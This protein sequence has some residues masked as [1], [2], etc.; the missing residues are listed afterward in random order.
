MRKSNFFVKVRLRS[1]VTTQ[2]CVRMKTKRGWQYEPKFQ[3]GGKLLMGKFLLS[4]Y[5]GRMTVYFSL[6]D[7]ALN[8]EYRQSD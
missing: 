5:V 7:M 3:L 8:R 1:Q 4:L 2:A 6:E